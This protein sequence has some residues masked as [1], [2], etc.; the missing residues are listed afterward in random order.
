MKKLYHRAWINYHAWRISANYLQIFCYKL[1]EDGLNLQFCSPKL[2]EKFT[3][4]E[5]VEDSPTWWH[6]V[7]LEH[8]LVKLAQIS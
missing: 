7:S 1:E 6:I 5:F 8:H 4:A 3:S 2:D